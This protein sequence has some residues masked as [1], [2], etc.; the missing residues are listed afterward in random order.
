[1]CNWLVSVPFLAGVEFWVPVC[2]NNAVKVAMNDD[3]EAEE[4]SFAET[5]V[6]NSV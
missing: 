2:R 5:M 1:M 6:K 4:P 3:L